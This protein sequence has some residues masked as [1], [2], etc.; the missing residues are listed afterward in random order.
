V[1]VTLPVNNLCTVVT[2]PKSRDV[3]YV[4]QNCNV[5]KFS[6][7]RQEG[8]EGGAEVW[9]HSFLTSTALYGGEWSVARPNHFIAVK[10]ST[11]TTEYEAAGL[12]G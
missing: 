12:Q 3:K 11:I 7:T 4:F 10:D 6:C 2:L 1:I 8:I 5:K 9:L